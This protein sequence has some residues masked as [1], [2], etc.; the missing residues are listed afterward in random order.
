MPDESHHGLLHTSDCYDRGAVAQPSSCV[1]CMERDL[2]AAPKKCRH[3]L[4]SLR[5]VSTSFLCMLLWRTA[6]I[7]PCM[8]PQAAAQEEAEAAAALARGKRSKLKRAKNK[9]AHQD[10]D[11]RQL[12]LEVLAP[13]GMGYSISLS[14]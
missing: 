2:R 10:E 3:R 4:L 8:H 1:L 6:V 13:A 14:S 9:Y 7:W 5:E 12:A 11:D